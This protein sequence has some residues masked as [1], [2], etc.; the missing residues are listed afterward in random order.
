MTAAEILSRIALFRGLSPEEVAEV[1]QRCRHRV[2][3]PGDRVFFAGD[4]GHH[5]YFVGSGRIKIHLTDVAGEDLYYGYVS[6]GEFFGELSVIDGEPRSANATC[7]EEAEIASLNRDP[8]FEC[9]ARF[10]AMN[11]CLMESLSRRLRNTDPQLE[12]ISVMDVYGRVARQ[13]LELARL[14]GVV[15]ERGPEIRLDLSPAD[16]ALLAGASPDSVAWVLSYFES[17]GYI[18]R[19]GSRLTLIHT[20]ALEKRIRASSG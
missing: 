18:T 8:F 5:V 2:C 15:T 17:R 14:H 13:L 3:A 9:L 7:V 16:L 6:P 20:S 12:M 10:P 4:M 11:R 19:E 1:A